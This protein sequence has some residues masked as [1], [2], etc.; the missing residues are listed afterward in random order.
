LVVRD[1]GSVDDTLG[2]VH[3]RAARD[4]R[5]TLLPPDGRNLRAPASF[6]VLL[7]HARAIGASYVFLADQDDVWHPNK[8]EYSLDVLRRL[9]RERGTD[10][11]L[12][13]HTD[14]EVVGPRLEPIAPSFAKLQRLPGPGGWHLSR[15]LVQNVVTGCTAAMNR[16]LLDVVVPFPAVAMHDWWVAQCAAAFG[17]IEYLPCATVRYRQHGQ[18]VVG[19]KGFAALCRAA[20]RSPFAWWERGYSNFV[21][22]LQQV[23]ELRRRAASARLRAGPDVASLI[24]AYQNAMTRSGTRLMRLRDVLSSGVRPEPPLLHLLFLAR[25][26]SY[27]PSSD[28][29]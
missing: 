17:H 29:Q 20:L 12:L 1:D 8:I 18:N 7:A 21:G 27:V 15:L 3:E 11:P 5:I 25:V 24:D 14:L 23:R 9:E 13:V 4:P 28:E 6:G 16:A 2:V 26:V 19:A 10:C 22:G